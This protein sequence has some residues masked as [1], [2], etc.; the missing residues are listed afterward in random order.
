[1]SPEVLPEASLR[2]SEDQY[3]HLMAT[4][5][6]LFGE[7]IFHKFKTFSNRSDDMQ[8]VNLSK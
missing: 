5:F 1:M 2:Y 6:I 3:V 8:Q 4:G 7:V